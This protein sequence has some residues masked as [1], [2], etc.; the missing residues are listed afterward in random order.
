MPERIGAAKDLTLA[1]V[2]ISSPAIGSVTSHINLFT[3]VLTA[4]AALL[5]LLIA[6]VRVR[7]LLARGT[8]PWYR[9]LWQAM[10]GE[11]QA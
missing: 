9:R 6:W 11:V 1:G 3:A 8:G 7:R 2:L 5:G 4:I 10:F